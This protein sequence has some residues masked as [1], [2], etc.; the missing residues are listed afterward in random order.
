MSYR[1]IIDELPAELRETMLR[2][3]EAVQQE[4]LAQ[5]AARAGDIEQAQNATAELAGAYERNDQ[6]LGR[7]ESAVLALA[8]AQG[9]TE[10]RVRELAEAQGRT[11][12]RVRE[13]AEAQGRTEVR[14][15]ELAE[16]QGRTEM[17][18]ERLETAVAE[19]AEAQGRTEM[20]L[21]RLETTVAEL[22]EAQKQTELAL[23]ALTKRVDDLTVRLD[24]LTLEVTELTRVVKRARLDELRGFYIEQRYLDRAPAYFGSLLRKLQVVPW[25]EIEDEVDDRLPEY[26]RNDLL[27]LDMLVRGIPR[28]R[29]DLPQLWLAVEVSGLI[30]V[31]DVERAQRR[32]AILR[33][34]GY[35][36]LPAVAGE[37][38]TQEAEHAAQ[39]GP[40][41]LVQDGAPRFWEEA[42]ATLSPTA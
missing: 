37:E 6:R 27:K 15:R 2:L 38:V 31:Y 1:S 20:R 29:P 30:G 9:R 23:A 42:L 18:L 17:R 34:L 16:A 33:R 21:E 7:L 35:P 4:L 32:A 36:T 28:Q 13:L 19:L 3:V 24:Q 40:V 25:S 5:V 26:E 10:A 14:V 8:E 11:E 39:T 22:A 12:A 41:V